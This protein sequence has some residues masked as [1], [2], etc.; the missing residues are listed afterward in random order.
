[1]S[2]RPR[3]QVWPCYNGPKPARCHTVVIRRNHSP[4][5]GRFVSVILPCR[6][7]ESAVGATVTAA[8]AGLRSLRPQGYTGEVIVADN[9][10]TDRSAAV[11][12]KAGARVVTEPVPGYGS[13]IKAGCRAARGNIFVLADAD[14]TYPVNELG[15]LV[16]RLGNRDGLVLGSRM[17][18][19]MAAG[20]MP[21]FNRYIGN[22]FLT[23]LLN[24]FYGCR[25]GDTQSGMRAWTRTA[26]AV[27]DTRSD[28]MEYASE[29]IIKAI[30]A[31]LP[32]E[33]V[34][35][36]YNRRI[37]V[38]KLS[39]MRD[40]WRH[41]LAI[42]LYSPTYA[43]VVPGA[44]IALIGCI[45]TAMLIPGPMTDAGRLLDT[46]T[47]VGGI[48]LLS[49]GLNIL[50]AGI[51]TRLYTVRELGVPGG[52]LTGFLIREITVERM[53]AAGAL[54]IAAALVFLGFIAVPWAASGFGAL[55][56]QRE[57][58]AAA[59]LFMIGSQIF[60]A[61]FQL[62]LFMRMGGS[63]AGKTGIVRTA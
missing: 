20:A 24:V 51:I 23:G 32:I 25:I 4:T 40:A 16:G 39:P 37:G 29:M 18:G 14:G 59:G 52:P 45:I 50:L 28:G 34:P 3:R 44:A 46:H 27:M 33:E 63:T 5:R 38:S 13:A 21:F 41:I 6:N 36:S 11:A 17:T 22:P 48:L 30:A 42:L 12:R 56:R 19:T 9:G 35:I 55:S 61:G 15:R 62:S 53:T 47:L 31:H 26:N 10:S 54:M 2:V 8:L 58:F 7:E 43:F 57:I 49:V 60:V 1:M